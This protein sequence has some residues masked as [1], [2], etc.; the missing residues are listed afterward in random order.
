MRWMGIVAVTSFAL[1]V[2]A[3]ELVAKFKPPK[4]LFDPDSISLMP[5]ASLRL[6]LPETPSAMPPQAEPPRS[7]PARPR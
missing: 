1:G 5:D 6:E 3:S 7:P 4:V 2:L